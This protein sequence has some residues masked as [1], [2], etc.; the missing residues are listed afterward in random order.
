MQTDIQKVETKIEKIEG[1][2]EAKVKERDGLDEKTTRFQRLDKEIHELREEKKQLREEK[3][4]LLEIQS[5]LLDQ[6]VSPR[7]PSGSFFFFF[8]SLLRVSSVA[9]VLPV[10]I[11]DASFQS[12]DELF[13]AYIPSDWTPQRLSL[14]PLITT[15][16]L[17]DREDLVPKKQ[18]DKIIFHLLTIKYSSSFSR[19]LICRRR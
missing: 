16:N 14:A 17:N 3:N 5:K 2:I 1:D 18:N 19:R 9:L 7:S 12:F 13:A 10:K 4:K 6:R 8:P 11:A 15:D